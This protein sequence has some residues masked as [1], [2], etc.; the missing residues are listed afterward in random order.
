MPPYRAIRPAGFRASRITDHRRGRART[1]S[2]VGS[3]GSCSM[4][5]K[6]RKCSLPSA[7]SRVRPPVGFDSSVQMLAMPPAIDTSRPHPS[8]GSL[9]TC[10]H[11]HSA[12]LSLWRSPRQPS[13]AS[14]AQPMR[15]SRRPALKRAAG[16]PSHP[17]HPE[18][19]ATDG[20]TQQCRRIEIPAQTVSILD[21]SASYGPN[22]TGN[23]EYCAYHA[24]TFTH[25]FPTF[26][27]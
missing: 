21:A 4:H 8:H 5:S 1:F 2:A 22:R 10:R 6:H 25:R 17:F 20:P 26:S 19:E 14:R 9:L 12:D 15:Q 11:S 16:H 3:S 27:Q 7:N 18:R 23:G 24:N 13:C